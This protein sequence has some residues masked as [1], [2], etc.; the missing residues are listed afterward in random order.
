M[1]KRYDEYL[2]RHVA[3][4]KKAYQYLVDNSIV[5]D[6]K[7]T[8]YIISRHDLSKDTDEEYYAYDNNFYNTEFPI[9]V[10]EIQKS[11]DAAWLHHIH[12]NK[13]HWQHWVL[14]NDDG[15]SYPIQMPYAYV[16][17]MVCDWWSFSWDR[18]S[19]TSNPKDLLEVLT[20]YKNAKQSMQLHKD[21]RM[22]VEQLLAKIENS[23]K[24]MK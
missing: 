2:D 4:V 9:W 22:Q 17:E 21:T 7:K 5:P 23:I 19:K 14:L 1:S 13:H 18:Y 16:I 11:F 15:T 20:W 8:K 24:Q 12:W 3:N 6:N 10:T